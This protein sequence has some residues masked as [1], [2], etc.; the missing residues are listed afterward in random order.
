MNFLAAEIIPLDLTSQQKKR[1][2]AELRHYFLEDP[3]LYRHCVDQMIRRCIPKN[4]MR[5]ILLHWH[6][7][8]CGGHFSGQMTVAKVLQSVFIGLPYSRMLILS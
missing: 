2:F 5:A 6:S 7:L 4:E 3:I 1:F 8:E